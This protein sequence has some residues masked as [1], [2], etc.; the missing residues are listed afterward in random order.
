MKTLFFALFTACLLVACQQETIMTDETTTEISQDIREEYRDFIPTYLEDIALDFED[1]HIE[2]R[3]RMNL[4]KSV[5]L[6]KVEM[7][8]LRVRSLSGT[9]LDDTA[10][11]GSFCAIMRTDK[12]VHFYILAYGLTPSTTAD[13]SMSLAN[14]D[15]N[16]ELMPFAPFNLQF[17]ILNL[18]QG[19]VNEEGTLRFETFLKN[20]DNSNPRFEWTF[21]HPGM[22]N[23]R[24][25]HLFVVIKGAGQAEGQDMVAGFLPPC[26]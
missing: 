19:I 21:N 22:I 26:L 24:T 5:N 6:D 15:D 20:G 12:G 25:A 8:R 17:D 10:Q 18:G 23:S 11:E 7:R 9:E 3:K 14:H 1:D 2:I 4:S 13:V 16:C